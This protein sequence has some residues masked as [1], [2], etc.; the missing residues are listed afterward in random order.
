MKNEIEEIIL[1]ES[2]KLNIEPIDFINSLIE[3][4]KKAFEYTG[5]Q[6][7]KNNIKLLSELKSKY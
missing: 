4:S 3:L 6:H 5:D 1:S 7:D 2:E